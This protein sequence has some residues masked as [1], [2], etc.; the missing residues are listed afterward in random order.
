MPK[1]L[2]LEDPDRDFKIPKRTR[3]VNPENLKISEIG[4]GLSKARNPRAVNPEN[5]KISGI[6]ISSPEFGIFVILNLGISRDQIMEKQGLLSSREK[7]RQ[8]YM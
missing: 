6:Y 5:P 2:N 1:S 8:T 7:L 4:I 3:V